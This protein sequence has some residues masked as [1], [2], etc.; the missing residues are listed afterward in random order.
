MRHRKVIQQNTYF[1]VSLPTIIKI[2]P[3]YD[4]GVY[5][6]W[7]KGVNC[8]LIAFAISLALTYTQ[9]YYKRFKAILGVWFAVDNNVAAAC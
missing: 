4:L 3:R 1:V 5:I 8:I 7:G 9:N 2:K 6:I